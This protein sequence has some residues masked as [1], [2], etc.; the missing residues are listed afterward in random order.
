MQEAVYS[1]IYE[2]VSKNG[3]MLFVIVDTEYR[4]AGGEVLMRLRFN[5]VRR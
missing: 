3:P 5:Y 1:D 4:T 2:R